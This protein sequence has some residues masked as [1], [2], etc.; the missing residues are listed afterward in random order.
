MK[1]PTGP[2]ETCVLCHG[3]GTQRRRDG[4]FKP[5]R[6]SSHLR[7]P[8]C[9]GEGDVSLRRVQAIVRRGLS[10]QGPQCA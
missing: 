9:R 8:L 4:R 5:G 2:F 7:C 10:P 6:T 3:R 1:Q